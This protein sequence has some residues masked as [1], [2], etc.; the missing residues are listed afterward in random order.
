LEEFQL[1][2]RKA[3]LDSKPFSNTP[4]RKTTWDFKMKKTLS[5]SKS[6]RLTSLLEATRASG[7]KIRPIIWVY[8][9]I[10]R[11]LGKYKTFQTGQRTLKM[12]QLTPRVNICLISN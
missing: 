1:T 2:K 12:S 5:R 4:K 7:L 9:P 3:L 11:N 10:E 8:A 6:L